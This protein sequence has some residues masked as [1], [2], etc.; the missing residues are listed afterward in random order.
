[1][2]NKITFIAFFTFISILSSQAQFLKDALNNTKDKAKNKS[3][4][5]AQRQKDKATGGMN[6]KDPL[7]RQNMG[8]A[9]NVLGDKL[10]EYS[11]RIDATSFN[12]AISVTDNS[13]LYENKSVGKELI[14]KVNFVQQSTDSNKETPVQQASGWNQWGEMM[15]ASYKFKASETGFI[16][17]Q[18]LIES[19]SLQNEPLYSLLLSNY[20]L[21]YQAAGRYEKAEEF[22]LK[23]LASREKNAGTNPDAYAASLNNLAVLY[24]ETGKYDESEKLFEKAI[25]YQEK[26][27][28]GKKSDAYPILLNNQAVLYQTLGRFNDAEPILKNAL[29]LAEKNMGEKSSNYVRLMVNQAFLY[30]DMKRNDEAEQILLKAIKIKER[31]LS[32]KSPDY[33]NLLN[34]IAALYIQTG[35]DDKV[36][37]YLKKSSVIYKDKFGDNHPS[38]AD[39]ISNL[40]NYYR[41]KGKLNDAEPLLQKVINIRKEK[42]GETHPKYIDGLESMALLKWQQKKPTDAASFFKQVLDKELKLVQSFFPSMSE[43]EKEK[44]WDKLFPKFQKFYAFAVENYKENAAL[45]GDMYTYQL[46]TKALLLSASSKIKSQI[47]AGN[48]ADLKKKYKTWLDGKENLSKIYTYSKEELQEEGINRD[49]LEKAVNTLEKDLSKSTLFQSGYQQETI[50]YKSIQTKLKLDEAAIEIIRFPKF[51]ITV[52]DDVNYAA[53]VL[54][55]DKPEPQLALIENGKELDKKYYAYYKNAITKKQEDKISYDQYWAKIDK[56]LAAKK[57]IYLSCDGIYNQINVNTLQIPGNATYVLDSK[58]IVIVT[59]TKD[60]LQKSL[61]NMKPKAILIGFPDYGAGGSIAALPGTKVEM[62]GINTVLLAKG[63]KTQLFLQKNAS[64]TNVKSI[65]NPKVLHIATHGFFLKDVDDVGDEKVFGIEPDKAKENPLLRA[66]L[67]LTGA[68]ATVNNIDTKEVK[69]KDNG[70]LSAY[71]A[72]NLTLDQ[73]DLVVLSACETGL[74]DIKNGEGVYGLQRAFKVAGAKALLMS[75]WKVN[76][77]AT[78]QLMTSFYKNWTVTGNKIRAFKTAQLELKTK[79]KNPYYWG[80]FVLVGVN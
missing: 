16:K 52:Q 48:D 22:S 20:G 65:S 62:T 11:Q 63:Y 2:K 72:M 42:F 71:E 6:L 41:I 59:N 31:Q 8:I 37:D 45:L 23:A 17:A 57:T 35:K 44:F 67:L 40:G 4:R 19:N 75:L 61:P 32:T 80:A 73:T 5:E 18:N 79:F 13:S 9:K 15:Y 74:G 56:L 26:T 68:E 38:Y 70:I 69:S 3:E 14:Q 10:S 12:Y 43:S 28:D 60:I 54:T 50:T 49:S 30:K 53:L 66:G 29:S 76:D 27:D 7:S 24:K 39:A 51:N 55:K 58:N 64:E 46:S 47:L 78:Q 33:A 77:E 25:Q 34:N 36:E 21:M 1:M